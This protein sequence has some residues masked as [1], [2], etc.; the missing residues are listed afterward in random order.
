MY[1]WVM[2]AAT[3]AALGERDK[4]QAAAKDALARFPDLT[5]EGYANEAGIIEAERKK[6]A[7]TTRDAGFPPCAPAA[8]LATVKNPYRLPECATQ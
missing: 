3:L 7:E 8:K 4:A 1:G 6:L 2:R 5:A